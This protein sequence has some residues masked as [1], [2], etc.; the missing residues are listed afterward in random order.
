MTLEL[1]EE[2]VSTWVLGIHR[3]NGGELEALDWRWRLLE[4]R[5]RL[6][7]LDLAEVMASVEKEF[8][9]SPFE[10]GAP[11][12]WGEVVAAVRA[13]VTAHRARGEAEGGAS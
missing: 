1:V 11:G 12:T 4:P 8:G 10:R 3:R 9:V 5:L 6:D 7:S 13:G 2:R